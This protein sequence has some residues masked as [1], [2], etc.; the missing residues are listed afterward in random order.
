VLWLALMLA[1]LEGLK[2]NGISLILRQ[3]M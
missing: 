1:N 2:T 3:R